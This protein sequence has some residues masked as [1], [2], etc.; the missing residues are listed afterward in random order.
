MVIWS[1]GYE[2]HAGTDSTEKKLTEFVHAMDPTRPVTFGGSDDARIVDIAGFNGRGEIPGRLEETHREHP[3]WPVIGTEV[4]HTRQTRGIYRTK[5]WIRGRDFIPPWDPSQIGRKIDKTRIFNIPDLTEKEVFTG[6]DPNYPSSYDNAFVRIC[7]RQQ[8][9]RTRSLP[10][11]MGE[12]RWTGID[13]L[14]E[15]VWPNRGRHCGVIDLCGF[16]KDHYYFYQSVW[17]GDPMVHILPHWT[18]PGKEGVEI[19]V[20]CCTNCEEVE[21]YLDGISLGTQRAKNRWNL[22]WAVHYQ[23]GII[24]AEGK[25]N[26][27]TV[28]RKQYQTA[29]SPA[30]VKLSAGRAGTSS[31]R[32]RVLHVR[33][34]VVDGNGIRVPHAGNDV[35]IHVRG[36]AELLALENGDMLDH[37]PATADHRR[38]FNGLGIAYIK[39][40]G[41]TGEITIIGTAEGLKTDKIR[42]R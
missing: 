21:L 3:G 28:C 8:W 16:P 27:K 33:Y 17:T 13:Y 9:H 34:S 42:V 19:P 37:T 31:G 15:N 10:F 39:T 38:V 14:G 7:A 18:H 12:F 26:G 29:L 23:P 32:Q 35:R 25:I 22:M 41:Q 24:K 5:T 4:P 2:I 30:A 6:L 20:A 40:L 36:P 11:M 1:I